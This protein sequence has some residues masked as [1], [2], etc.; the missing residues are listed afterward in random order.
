[1]SGHTVAW[2]ID[3]WGVQGEIACHEPGTADCHTTCESCET[4]CRDGADPTLCG[5]CGRPLIHT[6]YCGVA[7]WLDGDSIIDTY[8][9]EKVP[10]RDGPIVYQWTGDGWTWHYPDGAA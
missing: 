4:W 3:T 6:E 5:N 7:V 2:W 1:M 9:G 8:Q 10:L